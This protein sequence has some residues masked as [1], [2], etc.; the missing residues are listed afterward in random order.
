MRRRPAAGKQGGAPAEGRR[1]CLYR[2]SRH[3][4]PGA[5][6]T[7][8]MDLSTASRT[9]LAELLTTLPRLWAI[10]PAAV[11]EPLALGGCP[12]TPRRRDGAAAW[13]GS[14][15]LAVAGSTRVVVG[16]AVRNLR[17][18]S[19]QRAGNSDRVGIT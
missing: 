13:A 5:G 12:A 2:R 6:Q 9:G 10:T 8:A 19:Q 7:C 17:Q 4:L 11:G 3:P 18:Q 1:C 16:R 15:P 14:L